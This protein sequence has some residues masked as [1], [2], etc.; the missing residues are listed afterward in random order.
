VLSGKQVAGAAHIGRQLIYLI[1]PMSNK[2]PYEPLVAQIADD[3]FV[4]RAL[5]KLGLLEV[6]RDHSVPFALQTLYEVSSY[7]TASAKH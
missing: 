7:K 6:Y 3:K 4:G 1:V 2:L 5:A